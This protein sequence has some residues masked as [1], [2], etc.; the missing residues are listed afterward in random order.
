MELEFF[1]SGT[2]RHH[3]NVF[4]FPASQLLQVFQDF[5]GVQDRSDN[6]FQLVIPQSHQVFDD[7][8]GMTTSV[9]VSN[10]F[11]ARHADGSGVAEFWADGP[12]IAFPVPFN[13]TGR[14]DGD[15][16]MGRSER[17]NQFSDFIEQSWFSTGDHNMIA[18]ESGDAIQ[19]F[20]DLQVVAF[21]FPG[22][23]PRVAKPA[24]QIASARPHKDARGAREFP[25]ALD[26]MK[27][28]RNPDHFDGT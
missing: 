5:F 25:L 16:L 20:G 13:R 11:L 17:L 6:E 19:N 3:Q 26:A 23:V 27:N 1:G 12:E 8:G 22:C 28:L 7:L 15:M 2:S 10:P 18:S 21:G 14:F 24:T 9:V 4:S